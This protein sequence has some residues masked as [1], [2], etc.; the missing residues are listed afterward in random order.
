MATY[1]AIA[2]A[3]LLAMH[4]GAGG[5]AKTGF[6]CGINSVIHAIMQVWNV[7][8]VFSPVVSDLWVPR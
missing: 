8:P 2:L 4:A 7:S 6:A 3:L 1:L 5:T